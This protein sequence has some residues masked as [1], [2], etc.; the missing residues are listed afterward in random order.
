MVPKVMIAAGGTGGHVFPALA[1]AQEFIGKGWE[2]CFV[3]TGRELELRTLAR[4]GPYRVLTVRPIKGRGF[5]RKARAF[6]ALIPGIIRFLGLIREMRLHMI[7]GFGIY[8]SVAVMVAGA[9]LRIPR[10]IHEQNVQPG[11]AN[12][13]SAPFAQRI[14]VSF[15]ETLGYFPRGRAELT[16]NPVRASLLEEARREARREDA[17]YLLVLGGSQGATILN[18]VVVESIGDLRGLGVH[19]MHQT[20]Y[21]DYD[22]VRES[23]RGTGIDAEVFPFDEHIGRF[24]GRAHLVLCR[25]GALTLAELAAVG[26]ASLLVPYPHAAD[27]HQR[28]NAE[29]FSKHG[30]SKLIP[31]EDFRPEVFLDTLRELI[32]REDIRRDMEQKALSLGKPKAAGLIVE[33]CME[34]LEGCTGAR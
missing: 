26:R 29:V 17:F 31:Q 10:A 21:G 3:G 16:G 25:S 5:G 32:S 12:R 18:R 2:V 1:C 7:L 34:L 11:L 28:K 24:Y 4:L 6:L 9:F 23:Y 14:F 20:G 19:L 22:W 8:V 30:A 15:E 27:G 13:L 33:R